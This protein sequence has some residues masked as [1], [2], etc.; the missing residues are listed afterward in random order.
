MDLRAFRAGANI[1]A[2]QKNNRRYGMC[3]AWAMMLDYDQIG[4]L[5]GSQSATGK[6]LEVGDV[7]GVSAL[8]E[9]Q[10]TIAL[11]FGEGHSDQTDKFEGFA[12]ERKDSALLIPG[13]KVRMVCEVIGFWHPDARTSDRLVHLRVLSHETRADL[14]YL[15]GYG[16]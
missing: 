9:N 4:M 13:A 7:V 3:C 14:A 5:V 2:F 16:V 12:V 1:L 10:A 15:D 6:A 11:R 8:A